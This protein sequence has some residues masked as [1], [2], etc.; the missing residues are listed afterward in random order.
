MVNIDLMTLQ[1]RFKE[2]VALQRK[3]TSEDRDNAVK[4]IAF[5]GWVDRQGFARLPFYP[6]KFRQPRIISF[7]L[8]KKK[9]IMHSEPHKHATG[10]LE[11]S[12]SR[13]EKISCDLFLRKYVSRVKPS[14]D[15]VSEL[16][17]KAPDVNERTALYY[18]STNES[19]DR[20]M[21]LEI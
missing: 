13:V 6:A 19:N 7:S 9:R 14:G 8:V 1:S 17:S 3:M 10:K 18:S 4:S 2:T 5:Q 20:T 16:A 15:A 11:I 21:V 12:Y